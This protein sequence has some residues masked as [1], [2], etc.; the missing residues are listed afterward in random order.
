MEDSCVC[1][2]VC[3]CVCA[4]VH[5]CVCVCVCIVC[6]CVCVCVYVCV[7]VCVRVCE[8]NSAQGQWVGGRRDKLHVSTIHTSNKQ[9]VL[10]ANL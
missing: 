2:C 6:V 10:T 5:V 8:I 9:T 7:C 3:V 1:V 4:C